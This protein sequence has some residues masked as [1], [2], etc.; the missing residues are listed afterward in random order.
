LKIDLYSV[1]LG[2][3]RGCKELGKLNIS[4][5]ARHNIANKTVISLKKNIAE[6]Y[7]QSQNEVKL[8][9][10]FTWLITR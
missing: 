5:N 7:Y 6:E 9:G 10:S 4:S 2:R 3:I 1:V 8:A